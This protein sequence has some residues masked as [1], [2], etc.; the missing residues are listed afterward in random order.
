MDWK[1]LKEI[2]VAVYKLE[3]WKDKK[4]YLVFLIRCFLHQKDIAGHLE[5][6]TATPER[7]RLLEG[8]PHLL[9]QATRQVFYK[10]STMKERIDLVEQHLELSEE[11]F[12]QE[13]LDK[14]Y[15][16][17]ERVPLWRIEFQDKPLW[18]YIGLHDGQQKEGC[19]SLEIVHGTE[20]LANWD[21]GQGRHLYQIIFALARDKQ[22]ELYIRVGA[23]QGLNRG[24]DLIKDATKAFFGYR[25]KNLMFWCLR[26]FAAAIGASYITAVTNQ[27][28]YAMNHLR[29]NRKLKVDLNEFWEEAGGK[30]TEDYRFYRLEIAEYRK[31]MSELKPS[32]RAQHRRRFEFLDS[33]KDA[34]KTNLQKY[35]R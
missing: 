12:T 3:D 18:L 21:W 6:L 11:I 26:C 10:N 1:K 20:D 34:I 22:G 8:T 31:D 35:L 2:G 33:V 16:K 28:Y 23:L 24:L 27:G 13:L 15:Y 14:V 30:A 5:F 9:D 19:L 7:E 29:L 32:K 17:H 4:R 25:P